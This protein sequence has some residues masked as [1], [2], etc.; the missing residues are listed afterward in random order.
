MT[1][2]RAAVGQGD[3]SFRIESLELDDPQAGEVLILM[4]ASGVCHTD[5]DSL[6]WGRRIILGHEGAGEVLKTGPDVTS[7][8]PGD[9]VM[10]NWAIP[11]GQCFQCVRGQ[12]NICEHRGSGRP[13]PR[14]DGGL[15]RIFF[16]RDDGYPRDCSPGR[17]A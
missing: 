15:E 2:A 11:C 13:L 17:G 7:W 5:W 14:E 9:R 16:A 6:R 8:K 3:G 12:E 10:L 1:E 4:R